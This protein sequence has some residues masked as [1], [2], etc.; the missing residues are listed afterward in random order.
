MVEYVLSVQEVL[1]WLH[2]LKKDAQIEEGCSDHAE[3]EFTSLPTL[4]IK[5]DQVPLSAAL[6][7]D[8][9]LILPLTNNARCVFTASMNKRSRKEAGPAKSDRLTG[10]SVTVRRLTSCR[11]RGQSS[12]TKVTNHPR[13]SSASL[14]GYLLSTSACSLMSP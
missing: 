8:L 5:W 13:L 9:W 2:N 6:R 10:A 11:F 4:E 12:I 14:D 1:D 7:S 3:K